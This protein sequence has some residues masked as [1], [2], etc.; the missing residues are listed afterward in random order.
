MK[1]R[2]LSNRYELITLLSNQFG[3]LA[4]CS[5]LMLNKVVTFLSQLC[6]MASPEGGD[7]EECFRIRLYVSG[8]PS[9][10][11]SSDDDCDSGVSADGSQQSG[12]LSSSGGTSSPVDSGKELS[13]SDSDK[14]SQE[15]WRSGSR[16]G[17][18]SVSEVSLQ[19]ALLTL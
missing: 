8:S 1:I 9:V 3:S 15:L 14:E 2:A 4:F 19:T 6:V 13:T 7:S 10:V 17:R 16:S 11:C 12:L 5:Q 18:R